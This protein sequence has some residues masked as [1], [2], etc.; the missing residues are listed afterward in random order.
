VFLIR[1]LKETP[2]K[3]LTL[4]CAAFRYALQTLRSGF[5]GKASQLHGYFPDR[6]VPVVTPPVAHTAHNGLI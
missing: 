4:S 1:E 5:F 3:R 2:R 6:F